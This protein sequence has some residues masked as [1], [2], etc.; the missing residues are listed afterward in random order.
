MIG[1]KMFVSK[2]HH[3]ENDP[4]NR[5]RKITLDFFKNKAN[6]FTNREIAEVDAL[7]VGESW[8]PESGKGTHTITRIL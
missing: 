8:R 6:G 5:S 2:W 7:I 4:A 1:R 3:G